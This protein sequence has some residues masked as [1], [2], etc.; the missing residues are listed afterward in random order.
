MLNTLRI[1]LVA[2]L[3]LHMTAQANPTTDALGKCL[4]DSS[5][6]KDRK[7]LAKWIF[8]AMSAHPEIGSISR[9]SPESIESIQRT[10]A[11]LFTRLISEACPSEMRAVI[12]SDGTEG[13]KVSFEYLGKMAM[14]ELMSNAQVSGAIGGIERYVDKAKVEPVLKPH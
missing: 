13:I 14:Q 6:G 3:S 10:S 8:V 2:A 12:K 4:S 9:A 11:A 5:T 1:L 7:D